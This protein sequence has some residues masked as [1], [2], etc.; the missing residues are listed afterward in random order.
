MGPPK[1]EATARIQRHARIVVRMSSHSEAWAT[2][3]GSPADTATKMLSPRRPRRRLACQRRGVAAL[4]LILVLPVLV[5]LLGL[6]IEIGNIWRARV[7]LENA[8]E[9]AALAAV[10]QWGSAGGGSG[11]ETARLVGVEYASANT[12]TGSPVV[13][14][15][16]WDTGI[17]T[18]ENANCAGDL[19]FG[20][21]VTD[22]IPWVV[23]A[24]EPAGC[25]YGVDLLFDATSGASMQGENSWGIN[26]DWQTSPTTPSNLTIASV[27]YNLRNL[28]ADARFDLSTTAPTISTAVVGGATPP[29]YV[30]PNL[31]DDTSGLDSSS[32]TLVTAGTVRTWYNSQVEFV[33][34]SNAPHILTINFR[35][36][37]AADPT[38]DFNY[39]HPGD[40]IRFGARVIDLSS[41]NENDDGDGVGEERARVAVTFAIG[42]LVQPTT[43]NGTFVN[44][45]YGKE[46]PPADI[47]PAIEQ[48][49]PPPPPRQPPY[50]VLPYT[51]ALGAQNDNQ[52]VLRMGSA[53]GGRAP[54]VRAQAAAPVNSV[55]CRFFDK[56]LP[57]F[58]VSACATAKYDCATQRTEL[59][60]V[61][62]ENFISCP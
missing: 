24:N 8:L 2:T 45:N 18:N 39:F 42:G 5:L 9:A 34:D 3:D 10:K 36:R 38:I 29:I 15:T 43:S 51:A 48:P 1:Q 58:H 32:L 47:D 60:R 56:V 19:V 16:N 27:V 61:R 62:P 59:I 21:V 50:F 40:R 28:D 46:T 6:V 23:D 22:V 52:S 12:V 44:T 30:D 37:L 11:T 26:F 7:E 17:A 57:L 4:W 55:C 35:N 33:W 25:G 13:I 54:A 53:G 49:G 20:A 41:G 31:Q 14:D